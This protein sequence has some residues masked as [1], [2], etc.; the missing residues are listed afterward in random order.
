MVLPRQSVPLEAPHCSGYAAHQILGPVT[1]A[2]LFGCRKAGRRSSPTLSRVRESA[3]RQRAEPVTQFSLVRRKPAFSGADIRPRQRS[4][5]V[6]QGRPQ[7]AP[8]ESP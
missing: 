1:G 5:R 4:G 3:R 2:R 7:A 6:G 8:Q